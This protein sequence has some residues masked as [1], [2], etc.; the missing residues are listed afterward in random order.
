MKKGGQEGNE[1]LLNK[2]KKEVTRFN[3]RRKYGR[4]EGLWEGKDNRVGRNEEGR[5]GGIN[6]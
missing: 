3:Y 1:K 2:A 6:E 4:N 5:K